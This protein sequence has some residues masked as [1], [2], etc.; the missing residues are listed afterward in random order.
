MFQSVPSHR[1]PNAQRVQR[2]MNIMPAVNAMQCDQNRGCAD[3]NATSHSCSVKSIGASP[4]CQSSL[5]GTVDANPTIIMPMACCTQVI[6][7]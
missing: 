7:R 5:E 6:D 2:R 1:P 3:A 4:L